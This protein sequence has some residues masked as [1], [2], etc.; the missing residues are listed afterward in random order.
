MRE[1]KGTRNEGKET[2]RERKGTRREGKGR[3]EKGREG[4]A[5]K[6]KGNGNGKME[7]SHCDRMRNVYEVVHWMWTPRNGSSLSRPTVTDG[8]QTAANYIKDLCLLI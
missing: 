5:R 7:L 3:N 6:G 1:G 2:R 8:V 4:K